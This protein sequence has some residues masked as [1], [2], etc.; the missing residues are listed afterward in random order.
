MAVCPSTFLSKGFLWSDFMLDW[1]RQGDISGV[2]DVSAAGAPPAWLL[3]FGDH[4]LGES[5]AGPFV[6][7]GGEGAEG[8][9]QWWEGKRRSGWGE[10]EGGQHIMLGVIS[11]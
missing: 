2:T 3:L 11:V 10:A 6:R 8:V 5:P 7:R 9:G 4:L 1:S